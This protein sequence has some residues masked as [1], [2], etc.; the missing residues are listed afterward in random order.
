MHDRHIQYP[1]MCLQLICILFWLSVVV[2][3][4]CGYLIDRTSHLDHVQVLANGGAISTLQIDSDSP[5]SLGC[6][7][8]CC[9]SN[10]YLPKMCLQQ[11]SKWLL[12]ARVVKRNASTAL[13]SLRQ[14]ELD[15]TNQQSTLTHHQSFLLRDSSNESLKSVSDYGGRQETNR[16]ANEMSISRIPFTWNKNLALTSWNYF[17]RD[18][19]NQKPQKESRNCSP[20]VSGSQSA[21]CITVMTVFLRKLTGRK[22][23]EIPNKVYKPR[24]YQKRLQIHDSRY[25]P[26]IWQLTS[27]RPV[28]IFVEFVLW[29]RHTLKRWLIVV[30][31]C[32]TMHW[33]TRDFIHGFF[34]IF[35]LFYLL[36]LNSHI[37]P[38]FHIILQ[39]CIKEEFKWSF[40]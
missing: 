29:N 28:H 5:E 37:L 21:L 32:K 25:F 14:Q 7:S 34:W 18:R 11:N 3:P 30:V 16:G 22:W 39:W 2:C 40:L 10:P 1:F 4:C 13:H 19:Y 20:G 35:T 9:T 31:N 36:S 23:W 24:S 27:T 12:L 26:H 17:C 38:T 33:K 15:C 8:S 6:L